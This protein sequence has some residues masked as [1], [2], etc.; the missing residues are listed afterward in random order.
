MTSL[1][2]NFRGGVLDTERVKRARHA[3]VKWY[4]GTRVREAVSRMDVGAEG[5]KAVS[6]RWIH[7]DRGDAGRPNCG[8]RLVVR[9][10]KKAKKKSGV[11][12]ELLSG[13]PHLKR[14]KALLSL[15]SCPTVKKGRNASEPL[16][17]T[18][19]TVRTSMECLCIGCSWNSRM[20]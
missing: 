2:R 1:S 10:M 8:S 11:P 15:C 3:E 17:C 9:E 20:R 7:T 4:R 14:V 18:T 6:L 13:M 5:A 19:S 16:Q 12:S